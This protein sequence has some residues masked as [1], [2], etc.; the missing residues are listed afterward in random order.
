MRLRACAA[1]SASMHAV[2][3]K[4]TTYVW[5][6]ACLVL[7]VGVVEFS[8]ARCF[9]ANASVEQRC[10]EPHS[11]AAAM[12]CSKG[13]HGLCCM[14]L[15]CMISQEPRLVDV[16]GK[17]CCCLCQDAAVCNGCPVALPGRCAAGCWA[18]R[19]QRAPALLLTATEQVWLVVL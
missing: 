13:V 17:V 12:T 7:S 5:L 8:H 16:A 10:S 11:A 3:S 18:L 1:F 2:R 6:P 14:H 9:S 15:A 4:C 19:G